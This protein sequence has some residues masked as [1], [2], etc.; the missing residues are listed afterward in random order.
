MQNLKRHLTLQNILI[1][2]AIVAVLMTLHHAFMTTGSKAET[3][4]T[5]DT[6]TIAKAKDVVAQFQAKVAAQAAAS[7]TIPSAVKIT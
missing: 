1:I 7:P 6:A 3:S 5:I 2:A 4:S